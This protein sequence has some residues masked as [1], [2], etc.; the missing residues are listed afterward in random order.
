MPGALSTKGEAHSSSCSDI[1][2]LQ[3]GGWPRTDRSGRI[4]VFMRVVLQR[5]K[6]AAVSVC[7]KEIAGI[8]RGLLVL[9]GIGRDDSEADL[10]WMAKKIVELRIFDDAEGKLNLGLLRQA[11]RSWSCRNLRSMAIAARDAAHRIRTRPPRPGPRFY[12]RT[13]SRSCGGTSRR[14]AA[15]SFRR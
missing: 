15:A 9:A 13:S 1:D 7:G 6:N 8:G 10:Q 5:V 11:A 12:T 4:S 2:G 3:G 14:R